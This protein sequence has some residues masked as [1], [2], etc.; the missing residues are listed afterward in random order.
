VHLTDAQL[1]VLGG[2]AVAGAASAP[3]I[4]EPT[5]IPLAATLAAALFGAR[6]RLRGA[7]HEEVSRKALDGGFI[8]TA[9]GLLTYLTA[10][11]ANL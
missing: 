2:A 5:I 7:S 6:A 1:A 9:A 4:G 10:L 3:D 11:G 8:G